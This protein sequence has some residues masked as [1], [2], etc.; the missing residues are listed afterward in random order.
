MGHAE[1]RRQQSN[2]PRAA[3]GLSDADKARLAEFGRLEAALEG[4]LLAVCRKYIQSMTLRFGEEKPT[5]YV[6]SRYTEHV[7]YALMGVYS[8]FAYEFWSQFLQDLDVEYFASTKASSTLE[9]VYQSILD[10]AHEDGR[11]E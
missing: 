4:E 1:K 8:R 5:S 10:A 3:K 11:Y 2:Q 6:G 7:Q 9:R